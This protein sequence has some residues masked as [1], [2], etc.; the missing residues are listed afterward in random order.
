MMAGP[1]SRRALLEL[2]ELNDVEA[3]NEVMKGGKVLEFVTNE[4]EEEV[5]GV[6]AVTALVMAA[7]AASAKRNSFRDRTIV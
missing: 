3:C 4:V 5:I 2:D 6:K 7:A 1:R